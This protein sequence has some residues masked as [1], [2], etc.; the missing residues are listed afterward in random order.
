MQTEIALD[1][2]ELLRRW[3]E[4]EEDS[5]SPDRYELTEFG[6]LVLSP[7]P[8]NDHQRVAFAVARVA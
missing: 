2:D 8:T 7:K 4:L 6:E 1:R 3:K 5:D